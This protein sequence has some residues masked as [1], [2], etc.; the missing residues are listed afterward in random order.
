VTSSF[1]SSILPRVAAVSG[2][3]A[4]S[5]QIAITSKVGRVLPGELGAESGVATGHQNPR[6]DQLFAF[7][8]G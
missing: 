6:H 2:A 5:R 7:A 1:T 4:G 3:V 8:A